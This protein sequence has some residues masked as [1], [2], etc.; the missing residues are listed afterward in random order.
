MRQRWLLHL[1]WVLAA[2]I[3]HKPHAERPRIVDI[4][5]PNETQG[6]PLESFNVRF[7]FSEAIQAGAG[8]I[9]VTHLAGAV[10]PLSVLCSG[11]LMILRTHALVPINQRLQAGNHKMQIPPD[12]FR[13]K[14]GEPMNDPAFVYSFTSSRRGTSLAASSSRG[15]RL[16]EEL[17]DPS[18]DSW[19]SPSQ[20]F[21]FVFTEAVQAGDA[22]VSILQSTAFTSSRFLS[23][24]M[25]K[26]TSIVEF[27]G[28]IPGLMMLNPGTLP[29][30]AAYSFEAEAGALR[31]PSGLPVGGSGFFGSR[32]TVQVSAGILLQKPLPGQAS[33]VSR[34][35]SIVLEFDT[36]VAPGSLSSEVALCTAW[37]HD[38]PCATNV[39]VPE[40]GIYFIGRFLILRPAA[41]L[42]PGQLHNVSLPSDV[43]RYFGG[44][45][46]NDKGAWEYRFTVD[47]Q[48]AM[49]SEAPE[50]ITGFVDC[51]TVLGAAHGVSQWTCTSEDLAT[52]FT[53]LPGQAGHSS[54][55][56]IGS[57]FKLYFSEKVEVSSSRTATLQESGSSAAP[58]AV[59][60]SVGSGPS[61]IVVTLVPELQPCKRY[62]LSLASGVVT[63][64]SVAKNAYSG[65][66]FSFFV[67]LSL[68]SSTVA[69]AVNI[70]KQSTIGLTFDASPLLGSEAYFTIWSN[71]TSRG[72][73]AKPDLR[74]VE[75]TDIDQVLI[76]GRMILL[77]PRPSLLDART[78]SVSLSQNSLQ[79]LAASVVLRFHTRVDDTRKPVP[80]HTA[81]TGVRSKFTLDKIAP[82]VRFSEEVKPFPGR[83]IIFRTVRRVQYIID[84]AD[85]DCGFGGTAEDA[86]VETD[87]LG[88]KVSFYPLGKL[89]GSSLPAPWAISG[90]T[91]HIKL[92][93]GAFN[94][95]V[96]LG[97]VSNEA[98]ELEFVFRV[99]PDVDGPLV[100]SEKTLPPADGSLSGHESSVFLTF[101]EIV[102]AG[103]SDVSIRVWDHLGTRAP[104]VVAVGP[105]SLRR[106]P[107]AGWRQTVVLSFDAAVQ[108]ASSDSH[109]LQLYDVS[110]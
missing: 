15:P 30:S 102:E 72:K 78:Y 63:D 16:R 39:S 103:D 81:P 95:A 110:S 106:D 57:E 84:A 85:R 83:R 9:L 1:C 76:Q 22:S 79:F 24:A 87:M 25:D 36:P 70:P 74:T 97:A 37:R 35:T 96:Q 93:A 60:V 104:S 82:S 109:Q 68:T 101:N 98:D 107:D 59:A 86:C 55:V 91:Y 61:D 6:L 49:D 53:A 88:S 2:S 5:P 48:G 18:S 14:A 75:L 56:P 77:T 47:A 90:T 92:E 19:V 33:G 27:N 7:T 71:T 13:S 54:F 8:S 21:T 66:T 38:D 10:P 65:N 69:G 11:G 64:S 58:I 80:I 108:A 12:C 26:P 43:V 44:F 62:T 89:P 67:P 4:D 23:V 20:K 3:V 34:H 52:G 31:D 41:D 100:V 51:S 105:E 99:S 29:L 17:S 42:Q 40:E 28:S 32:Y 50:L 94:D 46:P 73:S 45:L